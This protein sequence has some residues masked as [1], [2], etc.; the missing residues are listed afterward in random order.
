[1]IQKCAGH[2]PSTYAS[3]VFTSEYLSSLQRYMSTHRR[4]SRQSKKR[5]ESDVERRTSG[6]IQDFA[7]SPSSESDRGDDE[8]N[9]EG[10]Y[11][12]AHGNIPDPS[13]IHF[14]Q[15]MYL[16]GGGAPEEAG[17]IGRPMHRGDD[18]GRPAARRV[19]RPP[20]DESGSGDDDEDDDAGDNVEVSRHPRRRVKKMARTAAGGKE[21]KGN[22]SR[23]GPH[24]STDRRRTRSWRDDDDDDNDDAGGVQWSEDDTSHAQQQQCGSESSAS[25]RGEAPAWGG[26]PPEGGPGARIGRPRVRLSKCWLCTFA[27]SKMAKQ[28]SAFVSASAGSM[29]PTIMADQIK[30][31]V[32]K[33]VSSRAFH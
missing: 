1:M 32:L 8:D 25:P 19:K 6:T 27:N 17:M 4:S 20:P 31:E 5:Y 15:Q 7:D 2:N 3:W 23:A 21:K 26:D 28:V 13:D 10:D 9:E 30:L 33:E 18:E 16:V 29:D 22:A 14:Q 24:G 12:H 11:H